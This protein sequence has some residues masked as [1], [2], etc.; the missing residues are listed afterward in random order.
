MR[1]D[2]SPVPTSRPWH[3]AVGSPVE[4]TQ[5]EVGADEHLEKL[6]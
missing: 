2:L 4:F 5:A 1:V 6:L 3:W